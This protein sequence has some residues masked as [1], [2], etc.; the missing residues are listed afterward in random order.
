MSTTLHAEPRTKS[1]RGALRR[2]RSQGK[3]PA[4]VYGKQFGAAA[5]A[6][7]ARELSSLLR[8]EG[9]GIVELE[10]AGLGSRPVLLNEVQRDVLNGKLLH[11]DFHQISLD[12]K[13]QAPVRLEFVGESPGE[14]EG[15]MLQIVMH[16]LEVECVAKD[17]PEKLT[18]DIGSL[19]IGDHLTVGQLRLPEG[20]AAAE[21]E[22][23]VVVSVLAPQKTLPDDE[24]NAA[25]DAAEENAQHSKAANTVEK[26]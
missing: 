22:D 14:K 15:G 1:S 12:E 26:S 25:D 23:A 2:L 13:I 16:E 7:D 20:V 8:S 10:I 17:L 6:L 18:A 19:Q 4:V 3:V 9:H 21:D 5:I 24:L 11:A